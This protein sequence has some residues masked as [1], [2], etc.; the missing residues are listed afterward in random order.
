[1]DQ[2]IPDD[3]LKKKIDEWVKERLEKYKSGSSE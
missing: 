2:L 3:D 1:M